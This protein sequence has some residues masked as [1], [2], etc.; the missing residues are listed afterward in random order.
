MTTPA[1][2]RPGPVGADRPARPRPRVAQMS[3]ATERTLRA[4][5]LLAFGPCSAP[6]LAAALQIHPRTARRLLRKLVDEEY[7]R[8]TS[9]RYRPGPLYALSPRLVGLAAQAVGRLPLTVNAEPAL[10]DLHDQLGR[11]VFI[12]TPSYRHVVVILNHGAPPRRW[13][14]LPAQTSA[15]GKVLLAHRPAWRQ[16]ITARPLAA[17]PT[18]LT[19]PA[20]IEGDAECILEQGYAIAAAEHAPERHAVAVAIPPGDNQMPI[21]ALTAILAPGQAAPESAAAVARHLALTA[22]RLCEQAQTS[23]REPP[24]LPR[25]GSDD[26]SETVRPAHQQEDP[27]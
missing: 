20:Q 10:A 21:A 17:S 5:E 27:T 1:T 14:L 8:S 6:E 4:I 22:Q 18:T 9:R 25:A 16:A 2:A 23:L 24:Q 19:A 15:A 13:E 3:Y 7:A 11:P 12:A 26:G